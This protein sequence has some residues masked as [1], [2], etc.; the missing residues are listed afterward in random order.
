VGYTHTAPLALVY[1]LAAAIV[2]LMNNPGKLA[3]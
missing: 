3:P 2:I 1:R